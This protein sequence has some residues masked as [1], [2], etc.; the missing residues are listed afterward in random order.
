MTDILAGAM[1]LLQQ[2]IQRRI[3]VDVS[4][5]DKADYLRWTC[6]RFVANHFR[7]SEVVFSIFF[8]IC[9]PIMSLGFYHSFLDPYL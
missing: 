6:V 1:H 3:V 2:G 5:E 4:Y 7:E 9:F 8:K